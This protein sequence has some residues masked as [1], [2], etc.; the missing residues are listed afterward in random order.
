MNGHNNLRVTRILK[1]LALCGLSR[2]AREFRD[3]AVGPKGAGTGKSHGK[4]H[5]F[6]MLTN[7]WN[8]SPVISCMYAKGDWVKAIGCW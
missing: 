8:F 2:E 7:I 6:A 4:S 5:R 1:C 3:F